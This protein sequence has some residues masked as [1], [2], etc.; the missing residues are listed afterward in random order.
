MRRMYKLIIRSDNMQNNILL[1]GLST[2]VTG[3]IV[4]YLG[5]IILIG[6][7][8]LMRLFSVK[9]QEPK[10]AQ[11]PDAYAVSKD[12]APETE[13]GISPEIIA[14]IAAAVA[15]FTQGEFS[16]SDFIVRSIRR[17]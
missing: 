1:E 10:K 6:A 17:S 8:S 2:I 4:V 15:C 3:F 14:C 5:L 11:T 16:Q 7:I 13:K 12:S 9:N